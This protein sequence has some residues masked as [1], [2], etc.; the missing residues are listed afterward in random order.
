MA[1]PGSMDFN[2]LYDLAMVAI[3]ANRLD[4]AKDLLSQQDFSSLFRD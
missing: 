4:E 3:K 2:A 1:A